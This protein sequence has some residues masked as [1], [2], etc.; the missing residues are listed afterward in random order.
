MRGVL[1][2]QRGEEALHVQELT[3]LEL[4]LSVWGGGETKSHPRSSLLSFP[5]CSR[6]A[7]TAGRW[8]HTG[9]GM[10]WNGL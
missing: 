2:K 10:C 6:S 8:N 3:S 4:G 9:D 1:G 5:V 7:R